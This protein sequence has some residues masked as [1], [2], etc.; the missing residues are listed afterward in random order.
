MDEK[1]FLERW[2]KSLGI[3]IDF[4]EIEE[5]HARKRKE[6]ALLE[7]FNKALVT[8]VVKKEVD[9]VIKEPV[10]V[11]EISTIEEIIVESGK[12][13]EPELPKDNIV[14]KA[15]KTLSVASQKDIQDAADKLPAGIQKELDI[16]RKSIADFHRFAQ[17]HSQLGGGGAGSIDELT[18]QTKT[19]TNNSY[20]FGRK[21]YY[22]GVNCSGPATIYLPT[23]NLK[24][25]R[26]V[27]VKDESGNCNMNNITIT[28][29]DGNTIDNDGNAILAI[30][31]GSLTFIYNNGWRII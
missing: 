12:Q 10:L 6:A 1:A 23:Q 4:T 28:V 5:R 15:V 26:Q 8:K 30:N 11:E 29:A 20:Q 3:E 22:I 19:V 24:D 2:Q 9:P 18:F 17:R 21:D 14:T 25:G 7:Q 27:V 16:I 31:N 13:I